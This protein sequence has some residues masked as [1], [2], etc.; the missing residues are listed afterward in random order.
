LQHWEEITAVSFG[1]IILYIVKNNLFKRNGSYLLPL[2]QSIHPRH[3][4]TLLNDLWIQFDRVARMSAARAP[5]RSTFFGLKPDQNYH[6]Y[7]AGIYH[8][9]LKRSDFSFVRQDPQESIAGAVMIGAPMHSIGAPREA[10]MDLQTS[11]GCTK[12][13]IWYNTL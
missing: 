2:L 12:N 1:Q 11:F 5:L 3:P 8:A 9:Q 10:Q 13:F 4:G 7:C 6:V